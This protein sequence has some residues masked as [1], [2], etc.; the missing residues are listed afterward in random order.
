MKQAATSPTRWRNAG[1]RSQTPAPFLRYRQ[2]TASASLTDWLASSTS[3]AYPR[4]HS[5]QIPKRT[6]SSEGGVG[7][8]AILTELTDAELRMLLVELPVGHHQL[9]PCLQRPGCARLM[10]RSGPPIVR[11]LVLFHSKGC[12]DLHSP[13]LSHTS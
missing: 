3:S 12:P 2:H 5:N 1:R 11:S 7:N 13:S 4:G 10:H 9:C 8:L 6:Q